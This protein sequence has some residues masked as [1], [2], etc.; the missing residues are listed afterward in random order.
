MDDDDEDEEKHALVIYTPRKPHS[1]L[2]LRRKRQEANINEDEEEVANVKKRRQNLH[3]EQSLYK[4]EEQQIKERA[5]AAGLAKMQ[6]YLSKLLDADD[7]DEEEHALVKYTPTKHH[8]NLHLRRK[9][10][11]ANIDEDEEEVAN[12]KK[13]C[14]NLHVEQSLCKVEEEQIK[15]RARAG[16]KEERGVNFYIG[17]DSISLFFVVLTTIVIPICI[18]V[19]RFS[20]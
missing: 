5:R 13:R 12:V 1:N 20:I 8:N 6:H 14:Q 9:R 10:Q 11:E 17:I 19:G 4:V 7:E 2:H 16:Q 18:L 3:V 15:E